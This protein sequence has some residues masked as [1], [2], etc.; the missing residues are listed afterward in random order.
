MK[1][2]RSAAMLG[3]LAGVAIALVVPALVTGQENAQ[4]QAEAPAPKI[5]RPAGS[6]DS[7]QAINDDFS[8]QMLQLERRRLDRLSRLAARQDPTEAAGT[9]EQLFRLAIAS[10]LFR[11]AEPAAGTIVKA[12]TPSPTTAALAHLVKIIAEA[13]RGAYEQSLES[14]TQAFESAQ[15]AAASGRPH[16][17]LQAGEL[18]AICDAYYQR[19]VHG[20]QF[21]IARQA[22]QLALE[23]TKN[24]AVH[25]FL[26]GRL[27][28]LDLVGK[29]APPIEGTD[30]DG[31]PYRLASFKG[32][33]VLVVFW[34]SWCLPSAAEVEGLQQAVTAHRSK[35]FEVVGINLDTL[36]EGG[37]KLETVLPNVRR[38]LIEQNVRWPNLVNGPGAQ[39]FAKA[40]GVTDI[41]SS[42]L[43]GRD[44]TIVQLDLVRL[45]LEAVIARELAR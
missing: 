15:K 35:G 11:D 16:A 27:K 41:P 28:R 34:A 23:H 12:G 18:T 5:L 2:T 39:D 42:V 8:Q 30:L 36:Q 14:L 13:D 17:A 43:I 20:D 1:S 9:Y 4:D 40:Y 7:L 29:P 21:K 32:K 26:S 19:L 22:F 3:I 45:N 6:P 31:K 37:Q 38:F 44:G 24:P 10:N 25:E 33:V